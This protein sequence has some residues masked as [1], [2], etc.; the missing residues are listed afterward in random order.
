MWIVLGEFVTEVFE[1]VG[2][3]LGGEEGAGYVVVE[4]AGGWGG[5]CVGGAVEG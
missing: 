5:G 4:V 3:G 2:A 1:G